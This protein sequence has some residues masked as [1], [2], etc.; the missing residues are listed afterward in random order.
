MA[1]A[2]RWLARR[3]AWFHDQEFLTASAAAYACESAEL[4]YANTH[5]VS[6]AIGVTVEYGLVLWTLRL[7]ALG[8]DL[9]GKRA[10]ARRVAAARRQMDFSGVPSPVHV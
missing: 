6:G 9:G 5:Q 10:H 4:T 1:D 2:S 7:V 8:T 3:A